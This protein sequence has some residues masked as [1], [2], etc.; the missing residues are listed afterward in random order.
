MQTDIL[1][2]VACVAA[3]QSIFGVGVL[4]FGTP[5]LLLLG[6]DFVTILAILLPIS[7]AI[8]VVQ[9]ARH[10]AH[11]DRSFYGKVLGLSV[12]CI[13]VFL[14]LVTQVRLNIGILVGIFLILVALQSLSPRV[15]RAIALFVRWEKTYFVAMGI[16]H[17]LTNLGG[18]LLT[19]MIHSK[20]YP[21]DTAR[22]TAALSYGTFA[23]F[24]L[25][26]LALALKA[27]PVPP[28]TVAAYV[29]MG[30]VVFMA[31]ERFV[32]AR[33]SSDR[34]HAVFS[35]FLLCSG[36]ALLLKGLFL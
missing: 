11:L 31:M 26:T 3:V 35:G 10:H 28:A 16:I 36:L 14:L 32:Y 1:I 20:R 23:V 7:L 24:Q 33:L 8:N 34:Y 17:G 2:T 5:I 15:H 9:V 19:A 27:F 30:I 4:L 25:V 21:K 29:G 18:S 6:Y 12:P 13:I 22:T